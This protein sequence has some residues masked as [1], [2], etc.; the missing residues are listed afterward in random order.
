LKIIEFWDFY[1]DGLAPLAPIIVMVIYF[2]KL[3]LKAKG[4][5]LLF[6][7]CC[8]VGF[9]TADELGVRGINNLWLYNILP[10]IFMLSL[11]P[12]FKKLIPNKYAIFINTG[13]LLIGVITYISEFDYIFSNKAF[14]SILYIYF[15]CMVV[16]NCI[17]YFMQEFQQ[18]SALPIWRKN[19]FWFISFLLLYVSFSVFIW[20]GFGMM[21]DRGIQLELNADELK[22]IGD[23]WKQH[24]YIF[25]ITCILFSMQL[26][27]KK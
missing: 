16:F 25:T 27:W 11:F 2:S 7:I 17:F 20:A 1:L 8:C 4:S 15:A 3:T 6:F 13:F 24:N 5:V 22:Y 19:E 14:V 26:L 21:I 18:M 23:L 10:F 9:L 12:F